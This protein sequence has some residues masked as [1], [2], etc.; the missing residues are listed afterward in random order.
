MS[1]IYRTNS[2]FSCQV[3]CLTLCVLFLPGLIQAQPDF[4]PIQSQASYLLDRMEIL[5]IGESNLHSEIRNYQRN[6][7]G[8]VISSL[9]S[10][11]CNSDR[12]DR[13]NLQYLAAESSEWLPD[14]NQYF[15]KSRRALLKYFYKSPANLF[16]VNSRYFTMRINPMFDF[17]LG[18]EK[19]DNEPLFI[20][21]RGLEIRGSVDKKA[22]F[23]TNLVE[24]QLRYPAYVRSWVSDYL[25]IPGAGFYKNYKS[26]LFNT[27]S[28]YDFNVATAYVGFQ[29]SKHIGIQFGHAQHFIGNGYRSVLLSDFSNPA[30]F[31]KLSTR[32]WKLHYQNLFLELS[33]VSQVSIPDGTILP[34]KYAAIHYLSFKASPKFSIGFFEASIFHRSRQFEFQ[35]LNPV[36][37]YR[38]VEGMIGS[39]DNVLLGFNA[40]YN[41]V[42]GIQLYGQFMFDEFRLKEF[43]S[44]KGWWANKYSAQAGIKYLNAFSIEH[45]DLQMEYNSAQ[46]YTYSHNDP[47]DSYTHYNQALAHPLGANF[48]EM[49]WIARFRPLPRIF[50]TARA[51]LAKSGENN[52][53]ENWGSNPLLSYDD[54][55]QDYGNQIGQGISTRILLAGFDASWMFY[56]NLFADLKFLVRKKNS[57][58]SLRDQESK[59]FSFGLRMNL[60]PGNLDF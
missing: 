32:V 21:H 39:P 22:F 6:D 35:Y 47:Y 4:F 7:A 27:Q 1:N 36:I 2:G 51:I 58:E 23:Y 3:I 50:L 37:F 30:F 60:W 41:P 11:A 31:L 42:P 26:S 33:P 49:V 16:E 45:L 20:N 53:A 5:N 25:A 38:T 13:Y 24:S 10:S 28:A 48:R 52:D 43:F 55:V 57:G 29:V 14:S 34:K 18:K 56:H 59:L 46:P 17:Q 12:V 9:D 19:D 54:R 44:N 15:P 40:Q 8:S